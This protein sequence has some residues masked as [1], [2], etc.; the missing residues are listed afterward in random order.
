MR[1]LIL[2]I[3]IQCEAAW[4]KRPKQFIIKGNRYGAWQHHVKV[5]IALWQCRAEA[6]VALRQELDN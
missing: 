4:G 2:C 5:S 6:V 1:F 3:L